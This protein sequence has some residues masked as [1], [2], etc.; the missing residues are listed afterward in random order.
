MLLMQEAREEENHAILEKLCDTLILCTKRATS[1]ADE[2]WIIAKFKRT[3]LENHSH[4]EFNLTAAVREL[5]YHPDYF[6]RYFKQCTGL[7]PLAY[8]NRIR[9]ERAQELLR[10]ESSLSI[11]EIAL[12]C[13][14]RDPLYFS[15]AFR[16]HCGLSPLAYRKQ[17]A[18]PGTNDQAVKA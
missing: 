11:G 17:Y 8:L 1:E 7:A 13:G 18:F 2:P 16:K 14:Y 5:G 15:T 9:L 6:R 3:L 10:L 12:Q 4:P